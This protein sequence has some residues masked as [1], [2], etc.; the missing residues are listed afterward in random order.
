M[1][2]S[3]ALMDRAPVL[4]GRPL[5]LEDLEDVARRK[6]RVALAEEARVKVRAARA[7]IDAL[8]AG[9][10]SA[11]NV[12][13]VNTGFGALSETRIGAADIRKLQRNLIRSHCCGVGVALPTEV[14]R[15]MLLLRAQVLAMGHSGVRDSIVDLL[16]AMLERG[17]H[18]RVPSQGSVGASGDLAPLAHLALTMIGVGEAELDGVLMPSADAL[19]KAGLQPIELEAKEGLALINGTQLMAAI[20]ALAVLEGETLARVADVAGAMSVEALLGSRRPFDERLMRVR[21]HPGQAAS[22]AT[23]RQVLGPTSASEIGSSHVHCKKVQDAYSLRCMPQVH[24]ATRD[25]LGWA[26]KVLEVEVNAVTDNPLVFLEEDGADLISG[27]NFHGEYL[28]IALDLAAIAL[29]ELANVSERRVEQLVNPQLSGG[30]TPFLAPNSGLHS[31]FMIAQV[32]AASLVSENK[33]YSHP[34]S[35][36]SI[37]SSAGKEDHVSMGS[38]SALKLMRVTENVRRGLAIE[39]LAATAGLDQRLPLKPSSGVKAAHGFVRETLPVMT[40][41]RPL[42]PEIEWVSEQIRLGVF[43]GAVERAVGT[44]S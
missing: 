15:G 22:A 3:A 27:G 17:V 11:P 2:T 9:G 33:I 7:A 18:P 21:P 34:A 4:L 8:A 5:S 13:G 32:A 14:V 44:L 28:A 23:L 41:D 29:S 30:L 20:G 40:D 37:P 36:D 43:L 39:V 31:G 35:V 6:R 25:A 16:C 19:K 1:L 42:A 26:R 10:D 12:Y 38:I 24:G